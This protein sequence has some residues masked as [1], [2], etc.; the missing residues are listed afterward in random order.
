MA[1]REKKERYGNDGLANKSM[2][3]LQMLSYEQSSFFSLFE[4]VVKAKPKQQQQQNKR[5]NNCV[6]DCIRG[7]CGN[8]DKHDEG[9]RNQSVSQS[10][11]QAAMRVP[12][13]DGEIGEGSR[14][15]KEIHKTLECK[16]CWNPYQFLLFAIL[17]Q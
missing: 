14:K 15:K 12:P 3:D 11:A 5:K 9:V 7:N 16:L 2:A 1:E 13:S 17:F 10:L 4:S 8:G 6:Q